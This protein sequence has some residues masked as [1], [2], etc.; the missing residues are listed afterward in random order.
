MNENIN[1][2]LILLGEIGVFCIAVTLF[3]VITKECDGLIACFYDNIRTDRNVLEV[4]DEQVSLVHGASII[5]QIQHGLETNIQLDGVNIL[6]D[7]SVVDFD[8]SIINPAWE[9][10]MRQEFNNLGEITKII[11]Y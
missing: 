11:Y 9:Y 1:A 5:F 2:L 6:K 3:L 8:Y 7:M 4:E 10:E